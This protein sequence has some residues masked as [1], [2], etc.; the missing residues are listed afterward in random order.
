MNDFLLIA[1]G[2]TQKQVE[3]RLFCWCVSTGICSAAVVGTDVILPP[4]VDMSL[5]STAGDS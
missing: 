4:R 5:A 3:S 1:A 2:R